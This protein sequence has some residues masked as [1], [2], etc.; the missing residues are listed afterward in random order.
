MEGAELAA[1]AGVED[2]VPNSDHKPPDQVRVLVQV[3]ANLLARF[4]LQ[5]PHQ[6]RAGLVGEGAGHRDLRVNDA[7]LFV[8]KGLVL[9][10]NGLRH[11]LAVLPDQQPKEPHRQVLDP[12]AQ[13]LTDDGILLVLRDHGAFED[14]HQR[15]VGVKTLK[16]HPDVLIDGLKD[17]VRV[18]FFV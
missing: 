12:V 14:P 15:A 8:A 3:E 7:A 11:R 9:V 13:E 6:R 17:A 1:H 16:K 5:D 4:L 18:G 10:E 2:T